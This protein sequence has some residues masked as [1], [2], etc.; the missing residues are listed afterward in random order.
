MEDHEG[1]LFMPNG[2]IDNNEEEEEEEEEE[3]GYHHMTGG[4]VVDRNRWCIAEERTEELI[5]RIQPNQPSEQLRNAVAD[6]VQ[7]LITKCF[8]C[9]VFT[10]G[11]VPLKTYLPDGDIDLTTFSDNQSLKDT[12]ANDVRIMLENEEKSETAEF[13]VKEVQYIQAEVKI[14][15]CLVE[16]IVVDISFNQ[17]GGLCTLCFLEEVDHKI[18]QNHL[19]KRSIILIKAWCYY[20]SRILGAHHGLISTYALETLVLYIF[21]VYNKS[22]AGPL[23]VLYRFLEFFSNFDWENFC[24]SLWGPVPIRSLPDMTAESP[25]KDSGELLLNRKFLDGC[26]SAYAVFPGGQEN[27][28][29]P[30]VSKHFNVIDPLRTNNNLGRS[31]SKGNFF[32]IRSAFAF[33]AKRLARLL[34][35]PKEDIIPEINQ[36]FMNTWERHGSGNRP[37]ARS[38]G[39]RPLRQ[40]NSDLPNKPR[41]LKNIV[42]SKKKNENCTSQESETEGNHAFLGIAHQRGTHTSESISRKS[43]MSSVSHTQ[44]QKSNGNLTGSRVSDQVVWNISS[45]K[46]LH[47]EKG[48]RSSRPEYLVNDTQERYPFARTRSSPELLDTSTESSSRGR[49]NRA[50]VTGKDHNESV[51]QGHSGG[52]KNWGSEVSG[53][54]NARSSTN[55]PSSLRHSSSHLSIDT[56]ADSNSALNNCDESGLNRL[57]EGPPSFSETMEMHQ[58]EQDRVNLMASSGVHGYSGQ[59][60]MPMNIG[61]PRLPFPIPPSLLASIGYSQRNLSGMVPSSIPLV[62]PHWGTNVHIPQGL[63]SSPLSHY[64]P[65][66]GLTSNPEEKVGPDSVDPELSEVNQEHG[67]QDF[68]N[69]DDTVS[70]RTFSD[71]NGHIQYMQFE[72]KKHSTTVPFSGSSFMR[73]HRKFAKENRGLVREDQ[74][75]P[76]R[77]DNNRGNEA[78]ST[79]V[80]ANMRSLA[81]SHTSSSRSKASSESSWDGSSVNVSRSTRD[82]RGRRTTPSPASSTV[83]GKGKS[84]WQYEGA[85]VDHGSSRTDDDIRE[86]IPLS[87]MGTEVTETSTG[88]TCVAS[89]HSQSR[90]I[91]SYDSAQVSGSESMLPITPM[92]VGSHLRHRAMDSSGVV[93]FAFYPTGPPVPFLIYNYP[94][95]TEDSE[96]SSS[97]CGKEERVERSLIYQPDQST[98]STEFFDLGATTMSNGLPVEPLEEHKTDILHSDFTSHLK[99][100]QYGR[101]CQNPRPHGPFVYHSPVAVP[102]MYMQ[103]HFP[104]EGPGRPLLSNVNH[105]TPQMGYGPRLIPVTPLQPGSSR[106]AG[107]YQHYGDETPRYRGGTGTYLPNTKVPLRDRP[108]SGTKNHR[109]NYSHDHNDHLGDKGEGNWSIT[110]KSRYSGRHNGRS[111]VDK[112]SL[113]TD[114]GTSNENRANKPWD[115]FRHES[116][117]AYHTQNG[118]FS[119]SNSSNTDSSNGVCG[120]YPYQMLN[121]NGMPPTGPGV[122]SV[123][124]LYS[125]D[126]NVGYGLSGEQVEFGSLGPVQM[127]GVNETPPNGEDSPGRGVYEQQMFRGGSAIS[128]PDQPCSPQFQRGI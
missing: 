49:R 32:R 28:G 92:L 99:N 68:W 96:G 12:W 35:C 62:D 66:M 89:Q 5:C 6:Y 76:C 116:L 37:D 124:M 67:D 13:H 36:F 7:R 29:Q 33:G 95:E 72:D 81:T 123:V 55:D 71:V 97:Q 108:S 84:G 52:K 126:Q 128:S 30:F 46:S 114:R 21:H 25:R 90:Q 53:S 20:E 104:W 24:V 56:S 117:S 115:S 14:I 23:E 87:T 44:G 2:L 48:R 88:H 86:W 19:F 70:T 118:P 10:F 47:I 45:N 38:A 41:N 54:C 64:F 111:Q 69:E 102:P 4:G 120:L 34:D 112:A 8:S 11:S 15:K 74:D 79:E 22:F 93:P 105:F 63:I 101:F 82:K 31:V 91:P 106:P 16:N 18:N 100:L 98:E 94:T 51:R 85:S 42:S 39:L 113:R 107:V 119:S 1:N 121:S 59:V 60:Q 83:L 103:G 43:N 73:D 57:G 3:G 77:Y 75:E 61:A 78:Y 109:G 58:E 65:G 80:S 27:Q 26:S 122:P 127:S 50:T 17:L 110:S 40:L 9:Q 125:Y